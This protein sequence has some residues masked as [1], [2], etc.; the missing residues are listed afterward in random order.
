VGSSYWPLMGI[1]VSASGQF[2]MS[3]DTPAIR[4]RKTPYTPS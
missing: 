2:F 4:A 3:A 1:F